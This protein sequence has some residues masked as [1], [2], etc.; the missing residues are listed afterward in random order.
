[1]K[2]IVFL[3]V[4]LIGL[5]S[6]AQTNKPFAL[7][8]GEIAFREVS[9]I[10]DR[11]LLEETLKISKEKFK[12]SLTKSLL[13]DVSNKIND[14]EIEE[15]V[16]QTAGM[17]D[18]MMFSEDSIKVFHQNF[19]GSEILFFKTVKGN[20]YAGYEIIDIK[21]KTIAG[22][23]AMNSQTKFNERPFSY[24][25]NSILR[26][27]ENKKL[28]KQIKGFDCFRVIYEYKEKSNDEDYMIFA[29]NIIYKR[30]MW[31]TD[32]IKS[33]FHPIIFEKSILEKYYPLDILETQSDIKGYE[34][35]YVLEKFDL[36]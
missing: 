36:K 7:T 21:T 8:K 9:K 18:M 27:S 3:F 6:K 12:E 13:K 33:L 30:E 22:L 19:R 25:N 11:M 5:G 17:M 26:I 35:K 31:V 10:T 14:K 2:K 4:L 23:S 24:S 1:M 15:I 28:R 32:K 16:E 20:A 29:G 34:K